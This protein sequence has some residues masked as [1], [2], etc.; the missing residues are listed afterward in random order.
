MYRMAVKMYRK[1]ICL[2]HDAVHRGVKPIACRRREID[3]QKDEFLSQV[4]Q[5]VRTP[6]TSI[7]S[8]SEI[9]L[10]HRDLDE[11]RKLLFLGIIH[12]G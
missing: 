9:L 1:T 2:H 11:A 7:R 10:K 12:S 6:M 8:F 5:E 4:S 3:T